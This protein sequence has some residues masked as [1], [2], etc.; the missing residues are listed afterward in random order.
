MKCLIDYCMTLAK[1]GL[2]GWKPEA[3]CLETTCLILVIN[4]DKAVTNFKQLRSSTMQMVQSCVPNYLRSREI[5]RVS[6]HPTQSYT[7]FAAFV[8]ILHVLSHICHFLPVNLFSKYKIKFLINLSLSK[9]YWDSN[10]YSA[11]ARR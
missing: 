7:P 8:K 2:S 1:F 4:Q 6:F 5:H 3:L 9:M 11:P 10:A